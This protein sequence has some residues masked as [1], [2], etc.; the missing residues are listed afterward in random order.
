MKIIN[1]INGRRLILSAAAVF[2]GLV[3][4]AAGAGAVMGPVTVENGTDQPLCRLY[5]TEAAAWA[6]GEDYFGHQCLPPGQLRT[7]EVPAVTGRSDVLAIF[8]DG[9]TRTYYG[10][11][12]SVYRYLV[13]RD[14]AADIFDQVPP[15]ASA[16]KP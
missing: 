14:E 8:E 15:K 6:F 10:L 4:S 1:A 5:L 3:L 7:V 9:L 16:Q 12:L 11:D 2:W 13:L